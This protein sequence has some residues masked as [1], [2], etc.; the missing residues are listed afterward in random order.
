MRKQWAE[1]RIQIQKFEANEYVATCKTNTGEQMYTVQC[2]VSN[3][4]WSTGAGGV[5]VGTGYKTEG[6]G[7]GVTGEVGYA[8]ERNGYCNVPHE[9]PESELHDGY[10]SVAGVAGPMDG[11]AN[12]VYWYDGAFWHVAI[13]KTKVDMEKSHS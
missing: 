8:T 1:P 9:I 4:S 6:F 10:A 3:K 11:V 2:N 13:G 5:H 7:K 12:T